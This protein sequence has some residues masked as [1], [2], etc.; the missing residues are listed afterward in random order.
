MILIINLKSYK[1][2]Y[3]ILY[4]LFS[5]IKSQNRK[6]WII[7]LSNA[8][9]KIAMK[10][11]SS[12]NSKINFISFGTTSKFEMCYSKTF[13]IFEMTYILIL[14]YNHCCWHLYRR[15]NKM[16]FHFENLSNPFFKPSELGKRQS[17]TPSQL[18]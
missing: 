3:M 8:C 6:I 16:Y 10:Q 1:Q 15:I 11:N 7:N 9:R 4:Q 13:S 5:K 2:P 17:D 18:K 14:R 12:F